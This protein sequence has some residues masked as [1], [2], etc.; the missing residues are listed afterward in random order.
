MLGELNW[1][2]EHIMAGGVEGKGEQVRVPFLCLNAADDPI[3]PASAI[4]HE[5]AEVSSHVAIAVTPLGGHVAHFEARPPLPFVDAHYSTSSIAI[6]MN[7]SFF[8]LLCAPTKYCGLAAVSAEPSTAMDCSTCA[9]V[10][11]EAWY[12]Y[13]VL[14][15]PK[16]EKKRKGGGL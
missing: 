12:F 6:L 15:Q 7:M 5:E 1:L 14:K 16:K 13:S 11:L 9:C 10:D 2:P 3:I 4:P 8:L